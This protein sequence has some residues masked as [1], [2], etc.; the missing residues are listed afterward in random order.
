[1][2]SRLLLARIISAYSVVLGPHV[3]KQLGHTGP[4][5][6]ALSWRCNTST[7]DAGVIANTNLYFLHHGV[8][9]IRLISQTISWFLSVV[10]HV[11]A[12]STLVSPKE[13]SFL[14][15]NF[16]A[17]CPFLFKF[18]VSGFT[19]SIFICIVKAQAQLTAHYDG[20]DCFFFTELFT[21]CVCI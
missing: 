10:F 9:S 19:V 15:C 5:G 12:L 4:Q 18:G 14:L 6:A 7:T 8:S 2:H 11:S 3:P 20:T 17:I 16:W 1:M 21:L 13:W